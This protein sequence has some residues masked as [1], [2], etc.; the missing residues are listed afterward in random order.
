MRTGSHRNAERTRALVGLVRFGVPD[1]V[2]YAAV[3][4]AAGLARRAELACSSEAADRDRVDCPKEFWTMSTCLCRDYGTYDHGGAKRASQRGALT[5]NPYPVKHSKQPNWH[6]RIPRITVQDARAEK[7]ITA[8][9]SPYVDRVALAG[10]PRGF[11]VK[12]VKVVD[13]VEREVGLA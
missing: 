9:L 13:G 8:L 3:R 11:V 4:I 6:G 2:S 7:R 5:P 12:V 10:D 1:H